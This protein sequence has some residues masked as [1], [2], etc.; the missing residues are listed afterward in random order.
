MTSAFGIGEPEYVAVNEDRTVVTFVGEGQGRRV[1]LLAVLT[2]DGS[3]RFGA[4][5]LYARPWPFVAYVR[6]KLTSRSE[7]FRTDIDLSVP[8]V[9][10]GPT[11]SFLDTPPNGPALA[12]NVAFHSPVLTETVSGRDLVV[13]VL[14]A[15][16]TASG[17]PHYRALDDHGHT[18]VAIYDAKVHGHAF[19]VA[20]V[21]TLGEARDLADMRIYSRPWPVTALF[22]GEVYKLLRDTLGEEFWQGQNPLVALGET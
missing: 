20:A 6:E 15:V 2:P 14:K 4:V 11:S 18:I 1:G 13:T 8:Y 17:E 7:R 19:Q 22:R 5:D 21:F 16:V 10:S 3:G 12:E 9:P